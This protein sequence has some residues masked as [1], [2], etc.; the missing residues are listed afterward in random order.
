VDAVALA[1]FCCSSGLMGIVVEATL[2]AR[3]LAPIKTLLHALRVDQRL[4]G[5]LLKLK[6]RAVVVPARLL[7]PRRRRAPGSMCSTQPH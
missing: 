5:R 7:L 6:V 3:P 4:P 1:H 2:V